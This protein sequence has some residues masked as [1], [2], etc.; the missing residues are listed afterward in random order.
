MPVLYLRATKDCCYYRTL[1]I[2]R[3]SIL[4]CCKLQ[5]NAFISRY[6]RLELL[7][8]RCVHV[9]L[10]KNSVFTSKIYARKGNN[11]SNFTIT[12]RATNFEAQ[13]P[14]CSRS[15]AAVFDESWMRSEP[16]GFCAREANLVI[17]SNGDA[18]RQ[19]ISHRIADELTRCIFPFRVLFPFSAKQHFSKEI[20]KRGSLDP[21][22]DFFVFEKVLFE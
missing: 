11:V 10:G 12:H 5:K 14:C 21:G 20:R 2:I 15:Q 9:T 8:W 13:L 6:L 16:G 18:D 17:V 7:I 3:R 22:W 1:C 19:G 4:W